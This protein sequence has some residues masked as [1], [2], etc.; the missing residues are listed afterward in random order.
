MEKLD[1]NMLIGFNPHLNKDEVNKSIKQSEKNKA[2]KKKQGK[3]MIS[4]YKKYSKPDN[5]W[6]ETNE[7]R[8]H[9]RA[10]II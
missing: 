3:V 7:F 8:P 5:N 9:Y 2:N 1:I 6:H 4:P 10:I